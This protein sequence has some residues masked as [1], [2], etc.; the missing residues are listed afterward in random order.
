MIKFQAFRTSEPTEPSW[1][2]PDGL[3]DSEP[4]AFTD[5]PAYKQSIWESTY[6]WMG[7]VADSDTVVLGDEGNSGEVAELAAAMRDTAV[8]GEQ[9]RI[10]SGYTLGQRAAAGSAEDLQVLLAGIDSAEESERRAAMWGLSVGGSAA[11]GALLKR[12]VALTPVDSYENFEKLADLILALGEAAV[13]PVSPIV[14]VIGKVMEQIHGGIDVSSETDL[15]ETKSEWRLS[16]AFCGAKF[17]KIY[18]RKEWRALAATAQSLMCVAQ[19]AAAAEDVAGCVAILALG[20]KYADVD[21]NLSP[22]CRHNA[23]EYEYGKHFP[24]A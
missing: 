3:L 21:L 16:T 23:C 8:G 9:K 14:A 10:G 24:P 22:T 18:A 17:K 11:V 1:H 20:Q 7:G 5:A 19:T 13:A 4:F 15:A 12:V 2:C 6:N